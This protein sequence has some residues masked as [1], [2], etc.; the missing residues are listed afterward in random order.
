MCDLLAPMVGEGD[1]AAAIFGAPRM[2]IVLNCLPEI[3]SKEHR[4]GVYSRVFYANNPRH[5]HSF[6]LLRHTDNKYYLY[7][8]DGDKAN[9]S[10]T[11]LATIAGNTSHVLMLICITWHAHRSE[12]HLC[13]VY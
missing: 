6:F 1:S 12:S 9:G 4:F 11:R 8:H 3:P 5:F 7:H 10:V 2:D 13:L